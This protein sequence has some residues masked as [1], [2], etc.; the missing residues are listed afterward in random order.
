MIVCLSFAQRFLKK[1]HKIIAWKVFFIENS[2]STHKEKH[3]RG[4]QVVPNLKKLGDQL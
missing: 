2:Y 4:G 3:L 1:N